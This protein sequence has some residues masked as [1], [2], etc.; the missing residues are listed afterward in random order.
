[1][2]KLLVVDEDEQSIDI[3]EK[4]LSV[5]NF[6]I[7]TAST[8]AT[9]ITKAK[10][11]KEKPDLII[12][13]ISLPDMSGFDVCR[14]LK[15]DPETKYILVLMVVSHESRDY[16]LRTLHVGADDYITRPFDNA[17]LLSKV[18]SLLRV[19]HLS[20]RLNNQ[21]VELKE[22]TDLLDFQLKMAMHVQRSIIKEHDED[23]NGVRVISKY[24]PALDIGGDF[25]DVVRLD[26][27]NIA[28]VI[29]DVSGHGISAALL[30]SMINMMFKTL[31][32]KYTQPNLLLFQMNNQFFSVFRESNHEMYAGVFYAIIDTKNKEIRYANAGQTFPLYVN[33][34]TKKAEELELG[35]I[36]VGLMKN[37]TYEFKTIEY[38]GGDLLL[39]HTDGL[40]DYFYKD[41]P[42]K[43]TFE[44][45]QILEE[46]IENDTPNDIIDLVL[47]SFY[48]YNNDKKFESDDVSIILCRL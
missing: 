1:M 12:L 4:V 40:S 34:K 33:G 10:M 19:K 31:V 27:D 16:V 41:R 13:N 44:I 30:T 29:G 2:D 8:G 46:G 17:I 6:E 48:D 24:M 21:Y 7:Y 35:G 47:A 25:Y 14:L 38:G 39:F 32:E 18:K 22:K 23:I 11:L 42:D 28:V 26:E 5:Q 43:F 20:D 45:K 9:A 3:F 36:P 37:T 15:S